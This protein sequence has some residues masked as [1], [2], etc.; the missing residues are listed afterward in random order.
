[1][2]KLEIKNFLKHLLTIQVPLNTGI[3]SNS[4]IP[5]SVDSLRKRSLNDSKTIKHRSAILRILLFIS[6]NVQTLCF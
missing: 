6:E 2:L 3:L 4:V 5:E 1:M